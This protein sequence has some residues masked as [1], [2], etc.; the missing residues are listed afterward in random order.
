[1]WKIRLALL[2]M[3]ISSICFGHLRLFYYDVAP[4]ESVF[5]YSVF[6]VCLILMAIIKKRVIRL[7]IKSAQIIYVDNNKNII[8]EGPFLDVY[9]IKSLEDIFNKNAI[10]MLDI[11]EEKHRAEAIRVIC[12]RKK[13]MLYVLENENEYVKVGKYIFGVKLDNHENTVIQNL[14]CK[15]ER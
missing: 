14:L 12:K 13:T 6:G 4:Y 15:Y 7:P 10:M 1:M 9:E 5:M 2:L 3:G 8:K 11:D